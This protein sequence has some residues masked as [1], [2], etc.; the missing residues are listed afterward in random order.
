MISPFYGQHQWS[1]QTGPQFDM[2][3]N[4]V[5][6][7][8]GSIGS[9]PGMPGMSYDPRFG[10]IPQ[11]PNPGG[12]QSQAIQNNLG[13][14]SDIE[15]LTKMLDQLGINTAA[16]TNQL[17]LDQAGRVNEMNRNQ[18]AWETQHNAEIAR[19]NAEHARSVAQQNTQR[20]IAQKI[21]EDNLNQQAIRREMESYVPGLS[22][23]L[24]QSSQN[25]AS[26][27]AGNVS[28][29]T[30]NQLA[31]RA[32]E[33]GAMLGQGVDS[34]GA[35]AALMAA[36]GLTSEGLQQQGMQNLTGAIGRVPHAPLSNAPYAQIADTN[37]P[38]SNVPY[39]N[40]PYA[41]VR[42]FDPTS[43]LISPQMQY[44]AQE[45]AN[46]LGAAPVPSAAAGQNMSSFNSGLN[47]GYNGS[48]GG[49]SGFPSAPQVGW[50][51]QMPMQA[52]SPY[53]QQQNR[54]VPY[55]NPL[56][57]LPTDEY[58]QLMDEYWNYPEEDYQGNASQYAFYA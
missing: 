33:R 26:Q 54:N 37:A 22:G 53:F 8:R 2:M 41:N 18:A 7:Y 48:L 19:L 9:L 50:S 4:P 25:M 36:L 44:G 11:T 58:N 10:G 34:P 46:W 32:A 5:G 14:L 35:N 55:G 38:Y 28:D 6:G 56:N 3:G 13:N 17:N 20:N 1:P 31:Q 49:Y 43:L 57:N 51:P 40:A 23:L 24:S 52:S 12:S 45:Q 15:R 39:A 47:R 21:L 30:W 42:T 27:L 29:S 16:R